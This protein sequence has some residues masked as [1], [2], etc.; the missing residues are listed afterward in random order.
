MCLF[1]EK[2]KLQKSLGMPAG[3]GRKGLLLFVI[4]IG[5]S[6]HPWS[7]EIRNVLSVCFASGNPEDAGAHRH[8]QARAA[9]RPAMA[10]ASVGRGGT[11]NEDKLIF[12]CGCQPFP[13]KLVLQESRVSYFVFNTTD[14]L[15]SFHQAFYSHNKRKV[16]LRFSQVKDLSNPQWS[17]SPSN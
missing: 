4:H 7:F 17:S 5:A 12:S 14:D 15:P 6:R 16:E 9:T 13:R 11:D 3:C 10:H 1:P 8:P 2:H